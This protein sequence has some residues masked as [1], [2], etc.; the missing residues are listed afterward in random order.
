MNLIFVYGTLRSSGGNSGLL[1]E[2]RFLSSAKT[3]DRYALYVGGIPYAVEEKG[4]SSIVGELWEV[5][6][7][8][9]RRIDLLEG[10]PRWYVR[11]LILIVLDDTNDTV[12]AWIYF[13]PSPRGS[14][15]KSGDYF[16]Q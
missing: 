14:I 9:F 3:A 5:D 2:A 6:D 10:H 4:E 11:K 15:R 8:T 13:N 16:E 12:M 1:R 7:D